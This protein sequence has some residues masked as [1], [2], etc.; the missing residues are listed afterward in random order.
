[1]PLHAEIL[2]DF[3]AQTYSVLTQL[4]QA[5]ARTLLAKNQDTY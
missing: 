2:A 3:K 1:L 4:N 5:K